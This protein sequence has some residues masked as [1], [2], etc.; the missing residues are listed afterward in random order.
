MTENAR[1][2]GPAPD[3]V[4]GADLLSLEAYLERQFEQFA[5]GPTMAD[6]L[7]EADRRRARGMGVD[8]EEIVRIQREL[9][10]EGERV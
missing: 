2:S 9:R 4:P 8:R 6:L 5:D 3:D 7:A 1:H 10:D